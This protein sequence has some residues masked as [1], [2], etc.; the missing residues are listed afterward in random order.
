MT[1]ELDC[2]PFCSPMSDRSRRG[3]SERIV[4]VSIGRR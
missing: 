3:E 4:P 2:G 1:G